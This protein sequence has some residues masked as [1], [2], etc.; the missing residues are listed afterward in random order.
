MGGE[1][2]LLELVFRATRMKHFCLFQSREFRLACRASTVLILLL[3]TATVGADPLIGAPTAATAESAFKDEDSSAAF[4]GGQYLL[5]WTSVGGGTTGGD[6]Y[7]RFVSA[8]ASTQGAI[9]AVVTGAGPMK[10]AR[11]AWISGGG[12][13]FAI[14]HRDHDNVVLRRFDGTGLLLG[15]VVVNNPATS[16]RFSALDLTSNGVD[17]FCVVWTGWLDGTNIQETWAEIRDASG[18]LVKDDTKVAASSGATLDH[19]KP[20][21]AWNG[22]LLEWVFAWEEFDGAAATPPAIEAIAWDVSLLG[23]TT[24]EIAVSGADGTDPD[25]GWNLIANEYLVVWTKLVAGVPADLFARRLTPADGTPIG[26]AFAVEADAGISQDAAIVH[27]PVSNRWVVA[28]ERKLGAARGAYAQVLK[29]DGSAVGGIF[30]LSDDAMEKETEAFLARNPASEEILATWTERVGST[31][32]LWKVRLDISPPGAPTGLTAVADAD[33]IALSWDLGAEADI[34]FYKVLRS[35]TGSGPYTEI[36]TVDAPAT[37]PVTHDDLTAAANTPYFYVVQAVDF[38]GNS[39]A[40]SNEATATIDTIAPAAPTGLTA[41]ADTDSINLS[42]D[43]GSESDL[44][45]YRVYRSTTSGSGYGL[46]ATVPAP[47]TGPVTHDDTTASVGVPYFYIVRAEDD[48]GNESGNSNEATATVEDTAPDPPTLD[49]SNV[50]KTNDSTPRITGGGSTAGYII[51]LYEGATFLGEGLAGPGG[52]FDFHTTAALTDG[53]HVIQARQQ[54]TALS[55]PSGFSSGRVVT[56]DTI[57]PAAPKDVSVSTGGSGATCWV[58]ILWRGNED[59]D[60]LGYNVYWRVPE[61]TWAK[62][63]DKPLLN[64]KYLKTGLTAGTALEFKVTAV[65]D[66]QNEGP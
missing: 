39:S 64:A 51:K 2:F 1:D 59:L 42:W 56:I 17:R 10:T 21:V 14:A 55:T 38:R 24:S 13:T 20:S 63:N 19:D 48:S 47:G 25:V 9:F 49:A 15:S 43:L 32:H 36:T 46:I 54:A 30:A 6:V 53:E 45:E 61:G 4:G 40:N 57:A 23:P 11:V 5:A 41:T 62:Y 44:D 18:S 3:V 58:E 34:D 35:E 37:G 50:R 27:S 8:D 60:L 66:A 52:V 22:S 7:A 16:N 31:Q 65:D 28:F 12:G 29:A 26:A 33:S